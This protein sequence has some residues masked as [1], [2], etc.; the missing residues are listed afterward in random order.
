MVKN[1]YTFLIMYQVDVK[2]LIKR[3]STKGTKGA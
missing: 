3:S 1:T 2:D